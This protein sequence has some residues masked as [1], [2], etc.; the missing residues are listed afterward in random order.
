MKIYVRYRQIKGLSYI[1]DARF[2]F[3]PF[4]DYFL[5]NTYFQSRYLESLHP[6][7]SLA[8]FQ[9]DWEPL[10]ICTSDIF[11]GLMPPIFSSDHPKFYCFGLSINPHE[12]L[13]RKITSPYPFPTL[14]I[15][16]KLT[17]RAFLSLTFRSDHG[18]CHLYCDRL[19]ELAEVF[20]DQKIMIARTLQIF[21]PALLFLFLYPFSSSFCLIS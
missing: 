15:D 5:V 2:T 8:L 16:L 17:S 7:E 12:P 9:I 11:L 10:R 13:N 18:S 14:L 21:Y 19:F 3:G 1:F 20:K 4:A 6:N